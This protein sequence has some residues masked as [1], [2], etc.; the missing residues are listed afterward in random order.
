MWITAPPGAY[1]LLIHTTRGLI[2]YT[3]D[4]RLHG[5]YSRRMRRQF[6]ET[7]E[8]PVE[9]LICEGTNVGEMDTALTESDVRRLGERY[10]HASPG[11]VLVNLSPLDVDRLRTF[12]QVAK[13]TGRRLVATSHF[14]EYLSALEE[15]QGLNLPSPKRGE[16]SEYG[17][18]EQGELRRSPSGYILL[19]AFYRWREIQEVRPPPGSVFIL[20]TSEPF[21]EE[22]EIE[23][24]RLM[25]WL[26][27]YGIQATQIHTSGHI[28][29]ADLRRLVQLIEPRRLF[30][31]HT[32]TLDPSGSS[33]RTSSPRS[34]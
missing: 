15:E 9:A 10:V 25:N 29:P 11:L 7:L 5:S 34:R 23:F 21:E 2:V 13:E 24:R 20:S 32:A 19:T 8:E 33:S 31:V 30:P 17:E 3:R 28:F 22:A 12:H 18:E 27:I 26:N 14:M 4:L 6:W 16:I 1:T